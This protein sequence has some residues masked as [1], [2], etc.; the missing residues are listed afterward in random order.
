MSTN[1]ATVEETTLEKGR[2]VVIS[3]PVVDVE[4]PPTRFPR[5]TPHSRSSSSSKAR[6]RSSPQR[7]HSSSATG[8]S[9]ASA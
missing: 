2:V 9:A 4:F 8:A 7:S 5:S 1:P 3:G 6:R